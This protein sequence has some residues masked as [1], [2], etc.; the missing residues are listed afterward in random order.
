MRLV[1]RGDLLVE[2]SRDEMG[3]DDENGHTRILA[4]WRGELRLTAE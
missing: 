4:Y 2:S 1:G 3:G